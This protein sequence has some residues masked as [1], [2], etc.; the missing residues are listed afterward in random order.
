MKKALLLLS[1]FLLVGCDPKI[2]KV[3]V[4]TPPKVELPTKPV[5]TS[6]GKGTQGQIARKLTLDLSS[7]TEYSLKQ[8]KII[9]ALL[10]ASGVP[11]ANTENNK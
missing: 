5:L 11:A 9:N 7:M 10:S 1:L 8:D 4:W 2:V 6:D 3:P